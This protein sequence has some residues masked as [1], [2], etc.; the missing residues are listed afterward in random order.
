MVNVPVDSNLR[1]CRFVALCRLPHVAYRLSC[2][3][4]VSRPGKARAYLDESQRSFKVEYMQGLSNV[5]DD[6]RSD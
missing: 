1:I 4:C 5:L 6:Q 2:Q 3:R